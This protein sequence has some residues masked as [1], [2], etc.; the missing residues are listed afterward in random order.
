MEEKILSKIEE[1]KED[2]LDAIIQMVKIDSVET[3]AEPGAP[4]G[5][6]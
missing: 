1:I 4:Y 5:N 2:M 6:Q 3:P